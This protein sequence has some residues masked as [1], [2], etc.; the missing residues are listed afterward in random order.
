MSLS[1]A[2]ER[3]FVRGPRLDQRRDAA[4]GVYRGPQSIGPEQNVDRLLLV[5]VLIRRFSPCEPRRILC[6]KLTDQLDRRSHRPKGLSIE[7]VQLTSPACLPG[8]LLKCRFKKRGTEMN[9][10]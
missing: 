8:V 1:C 3:V 10:R 6:A 5:L 4:A 2:A 9:P 7:H